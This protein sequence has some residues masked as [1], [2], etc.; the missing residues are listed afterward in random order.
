MG[1]EPGGGFGI[2]LAAV[3][4]ALC[5]ALPVLL[6]SGSLGG[7]AAWLFDGGLV[8]LIAAALAFVAGGVLLRHRRHA[9]KAKR[10]GDHSTG[11]VP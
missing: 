10:S 6:V 1:K 3:G 11:E 2:V 5:C 9:D 8:W 7:A 4:M